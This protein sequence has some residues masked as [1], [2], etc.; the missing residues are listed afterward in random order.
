MGNEAGIRMQSQRKAA[1]AVLNGSRE[2]RGVIVRQRIHDG[3]ARE[4]SIDGARQLRLDLYPSVREGERLWE[5]A[6]RV[7]DVGYPI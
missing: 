2:R 4:R 5:Y 7:T 3:I 1:A 6:V